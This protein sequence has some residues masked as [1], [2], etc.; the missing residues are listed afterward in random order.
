MEHVKIGIVSVLKDGKVMTVALK[1]VIKNVLMEE[2]VLMGL[3][4]ALQA[5]KE[6][7]AKKNLVLMIAQTMEF[8]KTILVLVKRITSVLTAQ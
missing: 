1:N 5:L 3:A 6:N 7:I 2:D 4:I 8:V